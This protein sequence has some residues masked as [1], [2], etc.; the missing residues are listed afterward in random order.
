MPALERA[1]YSMLDVNLNVNR[2]QKEPKNA[3][4]PFK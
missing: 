4:A 3:I 1:G 2:C